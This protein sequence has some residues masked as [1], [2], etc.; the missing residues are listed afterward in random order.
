MPSAG[1]GRGGG[2]QIKSFPEAC[3]RRGGLGTLAGDGQVRLLNRPHWPQSD[4]THWAAPGPWWL[5]EQ[6]NRPASRPSAAPHCQHGSGRR[7]GGAGPRAAAY[8]GAGVRARRA[9]ITKGNA[10]RAPSKTF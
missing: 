8:F 6:Q 3:R 7:Q 1:V 5:W 4:A 10:R 9:L 2:D